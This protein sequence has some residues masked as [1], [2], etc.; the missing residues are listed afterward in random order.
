MLLQPPGQARLK[1]PLVSQLVAD[2][3]MITE[4]RTGPN[5][6]A[7]GQAGAGSAGMAERP[8]FSVIR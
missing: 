1:L 2:G 4:G 6:V 3:T 7:A 8:A 5:W